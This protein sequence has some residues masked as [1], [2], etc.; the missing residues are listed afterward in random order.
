[1]Q[2]AIRE[3]L[4]ASRALVH[5]SLACAVTVSEESVDSTLMYYFGKK[6]Y[7]WCYVH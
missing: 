4:C 5:L 7:S 3:G 6:N 2:H 1:M